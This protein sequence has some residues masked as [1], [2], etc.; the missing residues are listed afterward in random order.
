MADGGEQAGAEPTVTEG[1]FENVAWRSG[2][3]NG[4]AAY[5]L[6]YVLVYVFVYFEADGSLN[7]FLT[8]GS[9]PVYEPVGWVFYGAHNV[10]TSVSNL[11]GSENVNY[12]LHADQV[13]GFGIPVV[14]YYAV[15]VVVLAFAGYLAARRANTT[16]ADSGGVAGASIVVGYFLMAVVG[17][18]LFVVLLRGD[19]IAR[20]DRT[21]S[22]LIVGVAY[23]I[24]AG[25]IG[26]AIGGALGPIRWR[27]E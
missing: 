24:I 23:P 1:L 20:P 16:R 8:P 4:I 19:R 15:P 10:R 13:L 11:D 26:G 25:A 17:A 7:E 27:R 9:D 3:V 21:M 18:F 14:V 22:I 6:G 12:L 2:L 5:L